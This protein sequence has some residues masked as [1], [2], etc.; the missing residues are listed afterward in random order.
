MNPENEELVRRWHEEGINQQQPDLALELC[1]DDFQFHFAFITPDYPQG[2]AALRHWLIG[3][4]DFFPG[5]TI[6]LNDLVSDGERKLHFAQLSKRL[7][8]ERYLVS[9][10]GERS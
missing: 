10:Q 4:F 2:A 5:F 3:T 8:E 6:E 7:T 9:S 1:T